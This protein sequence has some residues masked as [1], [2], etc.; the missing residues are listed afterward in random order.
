MGKNLCAVSAKKRYTAHSMPGPLAYEA[1]LHQAAV[2]LFL[3]I[4]DQPG[5]TRRGDNYF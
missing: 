4:L 3:P 2:G 1:F 5:G